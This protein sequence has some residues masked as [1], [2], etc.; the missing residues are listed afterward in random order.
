MTMSEPERVAAALY[1]RDAASRELGMRIVEVGSGT[2]RVTMTVRADMLNGHRVCH[3]GLVFALADS[4]F[5][6]SCNSYNRSTLAAGAS[7]DFLGPAY[8]G[9]VLTATATERWRS[10]RSGLYD[11]TV[12]NQ[13]DETLAI[14]RGRSHEIGGK[15]VED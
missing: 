5:A 7:I 3:G 1:A 10:R 6:F 13:N 12:T 2:A 9:D 11:I 14:F 8:E 4:A 15:I